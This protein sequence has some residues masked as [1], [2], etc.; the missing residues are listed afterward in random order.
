MRMSSEKRVK[1]GWLAGIGVRDYKIGSA[2]LSAEMLS[3]GL[4]RCV[5]TG[6]LAYCRTIR[7]VICSG[8]ALSKELEEVFFQQSGARLHNLYGPTEAAIDVSSWECRKED[9][10]NS[11]PIG[12]PIW[13]TSL[14]I[15]AADMN[16]VPVNVAGELYIAGAGLARGYLGL[17]GLTSERFVAN[18]FSEEAGSRM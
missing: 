11:I 9:Q 6:E 14:Y 1:D 13:N 15:L 10:A 16:P 4:R 2:H 18:P 5:M 8:E 3:G 7:N 12:S 17:P